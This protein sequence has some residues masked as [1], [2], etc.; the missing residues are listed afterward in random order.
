MVTGTLSSSR[1]GT[2]G[3]YSAGIAAQ[4]LNTG[5]LSYVRVDY[6]DGE[7]I[8]GWGVNGGL[9]YELDPGAGG[10]SA[11]VFKAPVF[12]APGAAPYVWTGLYGGALLGAE[13]GET[14]WFFP[15]TSNQT[16]PGVNGILGGLDFG[17]NQQIGS[18]VLGVEGDVVWTNGNGA[19]AC[20][21]AFFF[22]CHESARTLATGTGRLGYA[23]D[24]T[25]VYVKGGGAWLNGSA[26]ATCNDPTGALCGGFV[27]QSANES[28]F[29]PTVG[30][31][32]EFGLTQN[33]SAK[34][35]Y[36]F[37]DFG[38]ATFGLDTVTER[39][40]ENISEVKIGVNYRF[41]VTSILAR[42]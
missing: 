18:W 22:T 2:Y 15:A 41:P 21:N 34:A 10:G 23:W 25:L 7:F 16:T 40:R 38:T 32:V 31:G 20:P 42:D 11:G 1:V 13:F 8:N 14:R 26:R 5:W 35:E 27:S 33:W 28:R 29:G 39:I 24:R 3:D 36:D 37:L 9:R 12:K 6:L 17:Y 4:V 30:A 19:E